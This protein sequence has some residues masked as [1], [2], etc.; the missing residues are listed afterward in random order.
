MQGMTEH[1]TDLAGTDGGLHARLAQSLRE[2]A[3]YIETHPD[4]PIPLDVRI[5]Y[6]IPASTDKTG[7]DELHRIAAMLG[8]QVT[9][10]EIGETVLG[11][12]PVRYSATYISQDHMAAYKAHMAPYYAGQVAAKV[13]AIKGAAAETN[14]TITGRSAA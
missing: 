5:H 3:H 4:L 10:G 7:V 13:A 14:A 12:G 1:E 9:G 6:C 2:A 11:F 8:T